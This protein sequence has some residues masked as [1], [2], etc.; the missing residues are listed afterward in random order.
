MGKKLNFAEIKALKSK[1]SHL[2]KRERFLR[3][4]QVTKTKRK[5]IREL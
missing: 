2:K 5:M 4:K 1:R 3:Y